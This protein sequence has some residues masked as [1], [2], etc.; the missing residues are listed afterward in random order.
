MS[1]VGNVTAGGST[2]LVGS[3]L[4]GTCSTAAGTAAKVVTCADFDHLFTGVTIH[5]KF[6]YSN[7]AANAT[8]NVNSTGAKNLCRYG[9]TSAGTTDKTS[10][11]AGAVVSF[12]YDGTS[13]V[14]NDYIADTVGMT[15]III[16]DSDDTIY[17]S[18]VKSGVTSSTRLQRDNAVYAT[19][20]ALHATT[21]NG[22]TLAAASAK[23][24]DTSISTGSTSTNL[25]TS[26]AVATYVATQMGDVAGALVYKGTVTAES[27]L[28][29]V[30]L[31][32][33]WYY[34][35]AMP[36]AQTTSITIAGQTC[37]AGDM[38]IVNTGG[39]YTTSSA[40]AAAVDI[41]QTN[42]TIIS[43]GDIDTIVAS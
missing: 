8:L 20:G 39:T 35:V 11:S 12:T 6:T 30:A 34:I 2:H 28:L 31:K 37:E 27:S 29:N 23:G 41:I 16:D 26:A 13:W 21:F 15:S 33:G 14:M 25:P 9:T 4:Y 36:N 17:M 10:W 22:Y 38:V 19:N 3:T 24:V 7:T 42:T 32:K 43:N 40:L 1:Y 5:V 18:G